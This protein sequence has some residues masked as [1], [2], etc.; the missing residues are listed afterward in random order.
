M[1]DWANPNVDLLGYPINPTFTDST[2]YGANAPSWVDSVTGL[3]GNAVNAYASVNAI[4]HGQVSPN[5]VPYVNGQF[6]TG[7]NNGG[8]SPLILLA[9]AGLLLVL[10]LKD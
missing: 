3:L 6:S 1:F 4:N 7:A 8:I 10:F 2:T 9:G 5:G